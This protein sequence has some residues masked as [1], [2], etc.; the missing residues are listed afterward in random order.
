MDGSGRS[1]ILE[2]NGD[3]WRKIYGQLP[4]RVLTNKLVWRV[5]DETL[6][7]TCCRYKTISERFDKTAGDMDWRVALKLLREVSQKGTT[8]S[9]VDSPTGKD[10][11]FS[12]YQS[13]DV[14]HQFRGV[15]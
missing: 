6:R 1:V 14:I 10:L 7:G 5:P 9:V 15:E 3:P 12:V 13:W 4:W 8:W 11:H 2:C